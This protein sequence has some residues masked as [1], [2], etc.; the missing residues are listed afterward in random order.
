MRMETLRE[1]FGLWWGEKGQEKRKIT[2]LHLQQP[3][4]RS[5]D[6]SR[7]LCS[8]PPCSSEEPLGWWEGWNLG[9]LH[10][11]QIL[12][13]LSQGNERPLYIDIDICMCVYIHTYI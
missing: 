7:A 1:V 13:H 5:S 11:K 9:L 6:Q 4:Y 10:C 12:Y 2:L 8:S 3:K